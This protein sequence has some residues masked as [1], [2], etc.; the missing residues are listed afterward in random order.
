MFSIFGELDAIDREAMQEGL[1]ISR[2]R[3]H[4][5]GRKQKVIVKG[6]ERK[7]IKKEKDVDILRILNILQG[8]H[9]N[10]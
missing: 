9:E 1:A 7:R 10:K 2:L 8:K 3:A 4:V 5:G 6:N